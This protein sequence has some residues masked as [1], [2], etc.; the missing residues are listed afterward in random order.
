MVYIVSYD[1]NKQG[2]NYDELYDRIKT[3]SN[4]VWCHPMDSTWIIKC[5]KSSSEIYDY[6]SGA[7]DKNDVL[8][9]AEV[10]NNYYGYIQ[11]DLWE[12]ITNMF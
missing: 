7:I 10:T 4:D 1:L 3:I 9:I 2:Q 11:N 12:Y 6:L 8:F 5:S